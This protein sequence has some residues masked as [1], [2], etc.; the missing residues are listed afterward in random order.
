MVGQAVVEQE[1]VTAEAGGGP[2]PA[3]LSLAYLTT[4]Y[5]KVS[6]T[7]IR[8]E[9][10]ALEAQGLRIQRFALRG[11]D[12]DI[13]DDQDRAERERTR[14]VLGDGALP[15]VGA[16]LRMMVRRPRAFLSA[17]GLA[18][19]LGRRALR[20]LPYHFVYLAHACRLYEWLEKDP[21]DHLHVHFGTNSA[22]TALLLN[23]LGGPSYSFTVHGA[24][25]A[26]HAPYL[27]LDAKTASATFV[28]AISSYLRSQMLRQLAPEQWDKVKV[29][30]CGIDR[31]FFADSPCPFPAR[32]RFVC[33][34]R[35]S[36]EKGHLILLE[37]FAKTAGDAEL[38]L[39]GD[40][41]LRGEIEARIKALGIADR[42]RITGWVSSADVRDEIMSATALVQPSFQE[43]LPVVIMEA[44]A[45]GRP[46]ISTYVAGIP[47]LVRPDE[48]GWLVPASDVPALT[49]AM[50]A[51]IT[52]TPEELTT[53]GEASIAR[54]RARHSIDD[55]AVR[56]A[57]LFSAAG[58]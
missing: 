17:L 51:T 15:L 11:W 19:R 31:T 58:A 27:K 25:E 34:G 42:V 55:E 52:A 24:D 37:A 23:R 6:H 46:V 49:E 28:V 13:A 5:P 50:D 12:T 48:T 1:D 18:F 35:F 21:V 56:L 45:V 54:V 7:F 36:T 8:R 43:G 9:I 10:L 22:E 57:R 33:V 14:Y 39:V 29:V 30:H 44:M 47:E 26:D 4:E 53:M 20:P 38:V 41:P 16:V 3:A 32:P 40:G 2:A